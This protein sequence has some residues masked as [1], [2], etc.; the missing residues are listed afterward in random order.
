MSLYER[1]EKEERSGV[2][3]LNQEEKVNFSCDSILERVS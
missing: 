2:Y 1:F 3:N